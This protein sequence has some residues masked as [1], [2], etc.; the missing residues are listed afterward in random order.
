MNLKKLFSISFL[1]IGLNCFSQ[2]NYNPGYIIKNNGDSLFGLIKESNIKKMGLYCKFK[3]DSKHK[4]IEYSAI[5]LKSYC[6][7]NG[8]YYVSNFI[9][10]EDHLEKVFLEFLVNG[11]ADLYYFKDKQGDHFYIQNGNDSLLELKNSEVEVWVKDIRYLKNQKEYIGLLKY[12]FKDCSEI[13]PQI[14]KSEFNYKNLIQLTQDYHNYVCKDSK[15]ITYLKDIKP[16]IYLGVF[17]GV[18]SSNISFSIKDELYDFL[19]NEKFTRQY[20]NYSGLVF[21]VKNLFGINQNFSFNFQIG[22]G[23]N[24]YKSENFKIELQNI[25]L[26]IYIKYNFPTGKLSPFLNMGFN[27]LIC[28]GS[29]IKTSTNSDDKENLKNSIGYYQV[30]G[31]IGFGLEY[32]RTNFSYSI[33]SNYEIG[34]GI[35]KYGDMSIKYLAS[36]TN[37]YGLYLTIKHKIK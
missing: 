11:K 10:K 7:I 6:F 33:S 32:N 35:N 1:L 15:C 8:K 20:S 17:T 31:L 5:D 37:V 12:S 25:C 18:I 21:S 9:Q 3:K 19:N 34:P 13:Q 28:L 29:T 36:K 24:I 27:N 14:E 26:P 23:T 22:Y 30:C 2:S 16:R 4:A